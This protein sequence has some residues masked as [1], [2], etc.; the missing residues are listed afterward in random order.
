MS[1]ESKTDYCGLD[2]STGDNAPS[3]ILVKTSTPNNSGQ[4]LEKHSSDGAYIAAGCKAFGERAAPS[5]TYTIAGT[6]TISSPSGEGLVCLGKVT[7]ING[8]NYALQ[9]ISWTTG[10][11]AEPTLSATAAEVA[12]TTRNQF[13]VPQ[14]SI[15]PDHIAQIPSFQFAGE[16]NATPAFS[17][18]TANNANA[19]CELLECGGEISCSVK[20]NDKNGAPKAHDVTNA[21]I[22]VNITIAQYGSAEPTVTPASGWNVSSPLTCDDPDS[23]FPTWSMSI[24]R[25]LAKTLSAQ[26]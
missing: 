16:Q 20:T 14:F 12:G 25:P 7:P 18:P 2:N 9:S 17:L 21:H 15:L 23:D 6:A 19:G 24:S 13:K 1:W 11:D 10:A 8:K 26:S 3:T 4:Y 22:V 5:N